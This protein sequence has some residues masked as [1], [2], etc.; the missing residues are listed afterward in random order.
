M[1]D[2]NYYPQPQGDS[3]QAE[4]E[5]HVEIINI[6]SLA[7]ETVHSTWY[8]AGNAKSIFWVNK[9][10]TPGTGEKVYLAIRGA[11]GGATDTQYAILKDDAPNTPAVD[12][13]ASDVA[14]MI[15]GQCPGNQIPHE[16]T[17][18]ND[19]ASAASITCYINY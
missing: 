18:Y 14:A 4:A 13:N 17:F 9:A 3:S 15:A 11:S 7:S 16:F 10:G 8:Y 2:K 6:S 1:A 12:G 5:K 19:G